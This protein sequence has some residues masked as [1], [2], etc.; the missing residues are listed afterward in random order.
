MKTKIKIAIVAML[1][2]NSIVKAQLNVPSDQIRFSE[3]RGFDYDR[4]TDAVYF[5]DYNNGR[6]ITFGH[7]GNLIA[8]SSIQSNIIKMNNSNTDLL[9]YRDNDVGDWS[10]LRTNKGNGIGLIGQ[11]DVMA[12]SVLR[13]N[14]FVGIG[15]SDPKAKLEVRGKNATYS[16]FKNYS[17]TTQNSFLPNGKE[18]TFIISESVSGALI[19]NTGGQV[20]YKGGLSFGRGGS[21]IYSVN[22]NPAGSSYY[23]DIRFH[24][25]YWNG[26]YYN[27]DRMVIKAHGSVGI[28][29]TT[30][31]SW[32]LAVNGKIRAKEIKVETG[33]SDFVFYDDYKLPTLTEVE[34]HIKDK[35]HL[36]DIPSAEEVEKNGIFLGEMDSKLLQKIEELT[37][38]T[39]A[40][41]KSL[42]A[43][44]KAIDEQN[45]KI[46]ALTKENKLLKDL[47]TK[48]LAL[49]KRLE[50]LEHKL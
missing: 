50:K 12:L 33:W 48:L 15:I 11:P 34:N 38:Y 36:K 30:P 45:S 19:H 13:S 35:G 25:T 1:G 37:L 4:T 47:N 28:G 17:G 40:Q 44:K 41:E 10:L 21:G 22:P 8:K 16:D 32:K 31:G 9:I 43:H 14:S 26:A 3:A 39:I 27:A 20:T 29:T 24:T 49:Q 7:N 42:N 18:P 23:G 5:N 6:V 46:D 2:Y